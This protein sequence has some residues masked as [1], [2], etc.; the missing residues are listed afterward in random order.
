MMNF[1]QSDQV[2]QTGVKINRGRATTLLACLTSSIVFL[3]AIC[4]ISAPRDPA[5]SELA[6]MA[7]PP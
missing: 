3:I 6:A 5:S 2:N 4:L 1:A 7:V